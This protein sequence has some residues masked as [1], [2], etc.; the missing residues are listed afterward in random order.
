MK[1]IVDSEQ[2]AQMLNKA[3]VEAASAIMRNMNKAIPP[4]LA[5]P[6]KSAF[7]EGIDVARRIF[8]AEIE[9][10]NFKKLNN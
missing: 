10:G 2:F 7:E 3:K 9:L 8:L 4:E 1:V 5:E 6:L